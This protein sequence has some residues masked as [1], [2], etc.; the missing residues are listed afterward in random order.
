M[1]TWRI[2]YRKAWDEWVTRSKPSARE[3]T[4]LLRW[5]AGVTVDGPPNTMMRLMP[6]DDDSYL[7][8]AESSGHFIDWL[9][10]TQDSSIVV[11]VIS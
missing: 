8:Y 2:N 10:I 9:V 11:V 1:T 4:A 7:C 6:D 5:L 3:Q